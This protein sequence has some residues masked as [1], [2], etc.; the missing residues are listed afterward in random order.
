MTGG[1]GIRAL[2]SIL[3]SVIVVRC[4]ELYFRSLT[5]CF[6]RRQ[7]R[8]IP[9]RCDP[10][11]ARA[12]T[13]QMLR[14][15]SSRSR[16][17]SPPRRMERRSQ[18]KHCETIRAVNAR[19]FDAAILRKSNGLERVH[20][21]QHGK[22]ASTCVD[23]D[24]MRMGKESRRHSGPHGVQITRRTTPSNAAVGARENSSRWRPIA[25]AAAS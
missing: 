4:P 24:L 1:G 8:K 23:L 7:P 12:P 16:A 13:R 22:R 14:A 9:R 21:E 20:V 2:S 11:M 3:R 5:R 17:I 19:R 10:R 6:R 15:R 25:F 18:N